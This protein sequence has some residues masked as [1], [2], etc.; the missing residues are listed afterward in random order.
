MSLSH[1][2]SPFVCL[3][4]SLFVYFEEEGVSFLTVSLALMKCMHVG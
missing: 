3:L 4:A 1:L 2:V